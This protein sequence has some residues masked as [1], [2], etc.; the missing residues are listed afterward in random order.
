MLRRVRLNRRLKEMINQMIKVKGAARD[1][2]QK[3]MISKDDWVVS[4]SMVN[5]QMIQ[6]I[7]FSSAKFCGYFYYYIYIQY[8]THLFTYLII[9]FLSIFLLYYY[10]VFISL[11]CLSIILSIYLTKWQKIKVRLFISY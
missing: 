10:F 3:E 9:Q 1:W 11:W 7:A 5:H 4:I 8:F 2:K 6:H